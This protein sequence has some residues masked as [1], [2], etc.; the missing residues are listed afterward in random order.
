MSFQAL[1]SDY[2]DDKSVEL[3]VDVDNITKQLN[4]AELQD[5]GFTGVTLRELALN[6]ENFLVK[7]VT[8]R[9]EKALWDVLR[10][11][12]GANMVFDCSQYNDA[13]A[14]TVG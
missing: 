13:I 9:G 11:D 3:P 4:S 12:K 10:T 1:A 5:T 14:T 8:V 7:E 6:P 2:A